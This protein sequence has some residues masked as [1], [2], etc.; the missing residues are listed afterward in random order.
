MKTTVG[1]MKM[2]VHIGKYVKTVS[3]YG[4]DKIRKENTDVSIMLRGV[5]SRPLN[6]TCTHGGRDPG[7]PNNGFRRSVVKEIRKVGTIW[8][9]ME[10]QSALE[11]L[12]SVISA[13][14]SSWSEEEYVDGQVDIVFNSW[15]MSHTQPLICFCFQ[16]G[17]I[18]EMNVCDNLGDHLVGNVYVK[19]RQ[20]R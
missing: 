17:E 3:L 13:C 8:K 10:I 15:H 2:C 1:I 9:E 20:L 16:Y 6:G 4:S 19:V 14:C 5:S 18:E 7:R 11:K 12:S